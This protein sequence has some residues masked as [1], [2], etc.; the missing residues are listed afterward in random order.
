[1]S[2]ATHPPKGIIF[3]RGIV[4]GHLVDFVSSPKNKSIT[5]AAA[6]SGPGGPSG[7]VGY[8]K[9][10]ITCKVNA[11]R[12]AK[13]TAEI[14]ETRSSRRLESYVVRMHFSKNVCSLC[15]LCM[16]FGGGV[17]RRRPGAS[18]ISITVLQR[19]GGVERRRFGAETSRSFG[20]PP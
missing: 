19:G 6:D 4:L 15:T 12:T 1:M 16:M 11:T 7:L 8:T 14:P 2:W 3:S 20:L 13:K 10:R 18:E 9:K 5:P 17:E